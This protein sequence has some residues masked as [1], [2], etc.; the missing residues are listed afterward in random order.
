[1]TSITRLND[2][3]IKLAFINAYGPYQTHRTMLLHSTGGVKKCPVLHQN[4]QC[5]LDII[6]ILFSMDV[7]FFRLWLLPLNYL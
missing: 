4:V 2:F 3:K 7:L 6:K 1:M 5:R